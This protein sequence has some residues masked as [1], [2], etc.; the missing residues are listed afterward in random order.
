M[1]D[2]LA[3]LI[4]LRYLR[5]IRTGRLSTSSLFSLGALILGVAAVVL[6]MSIMNGF[7]Q[8]L[9]LRLLGSIAHLEAVHP[10]LVNRPTSLGW[11]EKIKG[12]GRFLRFEALAWSNNQRSQVI[13]VFAVDP[14]SE[15]DITRIPEHLVIGQWEKLNSSPS[16]LVIGVALADYL[17][18]VPGDKLDL[19]VLE[20]PLRG[21]A[22]R[23]KRL[24]FEVVALFRL[25]SQADYAF[26][27][28]RLEGIQ[29][30]LSPVG[31][32][33]GWR[34]SLDDA[35][36]APE[37]A[38]KVAT[39]I[40]NNTGLAVNMSSWADTF[41]SLFQAVRLEKRIMFVLLTFIIFIA[42][43]GVA[44]TQILAIEQK[45]SGIAILSAMG[46]T[47]G[48]IMRVFLLQG[49]LLGLTG[50]LLGA[51]SGTLLAN[52]ISDLMAWFEDILGVTLLSGTYFEKL[53]SFWQWGD[54][55][56]V[57]SVT[58]VLTLASSLCSA[59]LAA[60]V[61]PTRLLS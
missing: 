26:G 13:S 52:Y 37:Q 39:A 15:K 12:A 55:F 11:F 21:S 9:N 22:S 1:M 5:D 38:P 20:R 60:R 7:R 10:Q 31:W 44:A 4:G 42:A 43:L 35:L 41:G 32:P 45:L 17:G 59:F 51:V 25:G 24:T 8:E 48:G 46:M 57:T 27:F 34:F 19:L 33:A 6:V 30:L 28:T 2:K 54:L 36:A 49:L 3:L 56:A 58:L 16:G 23:P 40:R 47:T 29:E 53:P 18:L 50:V 14:E 61:R